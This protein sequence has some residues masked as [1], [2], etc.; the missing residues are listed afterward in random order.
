MIVYRL[1]KEPYARDLTG[2]GAR[3]FGGRWNPKGVPCV[4]ASMQVSLALLERF[5]HAQGTDDMEGL[6]L[7]RLELDERESIIY[8]IDD[9]KLSSDW[10]TDFDYSQWLGQQVL[11]DP[12]VLAFSVPS[13]I[14]PSE[15]NL[16]INPLSAAAANLTI[17]DCRPFDIDKRLRAHLAKR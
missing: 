3:L 15:R 13:A 5:V 14:V 9:A 8:H 12:D 16:I 10:M 17:K 4:Y 6:L 11:G 1:A 2:T 7:L